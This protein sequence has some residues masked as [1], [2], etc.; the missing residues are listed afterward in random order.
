MIRPYFTVVVPTHRRPALLREALASVANQSFGGSQVIVVDDADDAETRSVVAE[1]DNVEYALNDRGSGGSGARNKGAQ[2]A[3]GTWLAFLDD[4]DVW[5]PNKLEAV[6]SVIEANDGDLGLVYSGS[7]QFDS[8]TGATLSRSQPRVRGRVLDEM[9][10]RNHIGGMS[11]IVVRRDL[12]EE[13]GGFDEAFPSMQD[14]ELYVRMAERSTFDYVDSALVRFR[15]GSHGR[16]TFNASRKLA[17]AKL[18]EQKFGGLLAGR[19]S[20]RHRASARVFLTAVAAGA[21]GE[22]LRKIPSMTVGM[23]VDPANLRYVVHG[24]ARQARAALIGVGANTVNT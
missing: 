23:F 2:L 21:Y 18:F 15:V 6:K 5:M 12:F 13:I 24:L 16:I 20:H 9:L 8:A 19:P 3:S 4:D 7:E 17:G 10:Y 22:A 11:V 14:M 1:F